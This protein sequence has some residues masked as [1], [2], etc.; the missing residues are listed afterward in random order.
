[1]LTFI[2]FLIGASLVSIGIATGKAPPEI[3]LNWQGLA[4]VIGGT[5]AT[6]FVSYPIQEVLRAFKAYFV[7]FR[8]GEHDYI[9]AIDKM[10]SSIR[11]YQ[12]DG[13]EKLVNEVKLLSKL[14]ILKDGVQLLSN[15]YSKDETQVILEDQIRWKLAREM[16]Q[17]QLFGTMA[18]ISPA[19]GM[20]GTLIGLINMLITLQSQPGQ[21][22]AGLAIAL[23]TTFYGL[24]LANMVFAPISEKIKEQA[25][26]N[27]LIETMQLETILM[28]YE[29]RNYVYARD[30]LAAYLNAN[31]RKKV[32]AIAGISAA[33]EQRI[34]FNKVA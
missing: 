30:K 24:A 7:I 5:I 12:R 19:F 14:W 15:G 21:V 3:F 20:I 1:M 28:L 2:G 31:S 18:K 32:N 11:I 22:G 16:K 25:E 27:L 34:R 17:H 29:K 8:S 4:I 23:T 13:L 33:S 9:T 6:T 10:V 26:N